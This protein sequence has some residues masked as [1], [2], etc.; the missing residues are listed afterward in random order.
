MTD[1]FQEKTRAVIVAATIQAD[2]ALRG[3]GDHF[4][5]R[6][7]RTAGKT[8]VQA[9]KTCHGQDQGLAFTFGAFS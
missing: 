6:M 5:D 7:E 9:A 4:V 1:A 2:D 8:K 3:G